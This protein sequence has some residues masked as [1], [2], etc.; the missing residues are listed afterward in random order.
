MVLGSNHRLTAAMIPHLPLLLVEDNEDDAFLMTRSLKAAGIQQPI[1]LAAD[2]Q[3][4][5]DYL[6]G[7]G[8][9]GDRAEF[10]LPSLVLLDL[11]LPFKSGHEVLAWM[12]SRRELAEIVVVVLTSSNQPSDLE[13][14]YRLGANSYVVK[15]PAAQQLV[16]FAAAL[17]NYWFVFNCTSAG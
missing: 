9:Y 8:P 11:K 4:A 14:A 15:P 2:G 1:Q 12:R 3:R 7:Q 6:A 5:I 10:P 16:E 13:E 17:K